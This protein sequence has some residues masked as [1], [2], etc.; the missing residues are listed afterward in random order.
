MAKGRNEMAKAGKK[1]EKLKRKFVVVR[2][3]EE[4]FNR[5]KVY[6]VHEGGT[7][8]QIYFKSAHVWLGK[9]GTGACCKCSSA[10][11][12]MSGS[13]A[14]VKAVKRFAKR[15]DGLVRINARRSKHSERDLHG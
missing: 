10:L 9:D 1:A 13:C 6:L 8:E 4:D 2:L 12:G 15:I 11:C 14:H 3:P 5:N 7:S